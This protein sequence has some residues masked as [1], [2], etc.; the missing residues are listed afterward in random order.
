[1]NYGGFPEFRK[2][3]FL[4]QEKV[5]YGNVFFT[6]FSKNFDAFKFCFMKAFF[7]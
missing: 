7:G 5:K 4:K 1:M 6:I 2:Y 3:A